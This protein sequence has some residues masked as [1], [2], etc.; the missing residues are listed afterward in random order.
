MLAAS[1]QLGD[2]VMQR[3]LEAPRRLGRF[4]SRRD[5][6]GIH[7]LHQTS[8]EILLH[9]AATRLYADLPSAWT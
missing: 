9:F 2:P 5:H 4:A 6:T 8:G 1:D 7:P 3:S